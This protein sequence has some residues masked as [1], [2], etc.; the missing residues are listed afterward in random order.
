MSGSI[1]LQAL[2]VVRPVAV[3]RRVVVMPRK[4]IVWKEGYA[5]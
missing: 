2:M 1:H 3:R 4:V 5:A